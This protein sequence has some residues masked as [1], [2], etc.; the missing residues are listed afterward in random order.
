[1]R[2]VDGPGE[3]FGKG[4]HATD[5]IVDEVSAQTEVKTRAD[6]ARGDQNRRHQ[7]K[8]IADACP[9]LETVHVRVPHPRYG[10]KVPHFETYQRR[11]GDHDCVSVR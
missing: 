2:E 10:D 6:K 9:H 1:M 3:P 5:A 7:R 11:P 4:Y 8:A